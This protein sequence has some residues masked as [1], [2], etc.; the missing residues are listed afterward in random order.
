MTVTPQPPV[1]PLNP[2]VPRPIDQPMAVP[3][4]PDADLS[5]LDAA[6]IFIAPDDPADWDAWRAALERWREEARGRYPDHGARYEGA[7]AWASECRVIAQVWLWDE[8]L[9]DFAERRFTPDRLLADAQARFGGFD[10]VVL[11]HAYPVIGIDERN[12]WD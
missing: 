11:W 4:A 6:K 9:Y 3:L 5:V 2:L 12:Q 7:G 1:G 8:L 10:G